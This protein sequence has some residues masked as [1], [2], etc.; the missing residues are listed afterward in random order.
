[1]RLSNPASS[2]VAPT[3]RRPSLRGIRYACGER[4]TCC[5]WFARAS[6]GTASV[7]SP[8][9]SEDV[10]GPIDPDHAPAQLTTLGARKE[11]SLSSLRKSRRHSIFTSVT[12]SPEEKCTPRFFAVLDRSPGKCSRIDATLLQKNSATNSVRC[13]RG[14]E[15]RELRLGKSSL[16]GGVI[17][18]RNQDRSLL[19][20]VYLHS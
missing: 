19:A 5:N 17:R 8:A 14:F 15:F 7:L 3:S 16:W 12:G 6:Q 4:I 10:A 11:S 9:E 2:T 20:Q 1:M 13:Q 18:G